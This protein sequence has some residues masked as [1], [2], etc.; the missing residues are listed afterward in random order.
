MFEDK[1]CFSHNLSFKDN[2]KKIIWS[3]KGKKDENHPEGLWLI[4]WGKLTKSKIDIKHTH[5]SILCGII[6]G[7]MVLD[8]D[9]EKG[10]KL[11]KQFEHTFDTYIEDSTNGYNHV[12]IKYDK[13]IAELLTKYNCINFQDSS[14]DILSNGRF[15]ITSKSNNGKSVNEISKEF[16]DFLFSLCEEPKEVL[17][18]L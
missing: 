3:Y 4:S 2:G 7:Y 9:K 15:C 16:K 18:V 13:D 10:M 17:E 1:I 5:L 11:F 8:F 12:Y 6:N 14:M